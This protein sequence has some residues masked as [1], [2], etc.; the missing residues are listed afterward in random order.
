MEAALPWAERFP[1]CLDSEWHLLLEQPSV[2]PVYL[3][4]TQWVVASEAVH[5]DPHWVEWGPRMLTHTGTHTAMTRSGCPTAADDSDAV[6]SA[7]GPR[8]SP[9]LLTRIPQPAWHG[10]GLRKDLTEA[11]CVTCSCSQGWGR[12][13][14]Q[15]GRCWRGDS[16]HLVRWCCD[17]S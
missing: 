1:S 3:L 7:D 4:L 10:S 5:Q 14:K 11:E 6:G 16:R 13:K 2:H 8:S 15:K 17:S 9:V 12:S